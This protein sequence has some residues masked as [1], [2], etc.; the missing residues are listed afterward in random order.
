MAPSMHFDWTET[1]RLQQQRTPQMTLDWMPEDCFDFQDFWAACL[2]ASQRPVTFEIDQLRLVSSANSG[3]PCCCNWSFE[4]ALGWTV[5]LLGVLLGCPKG[6]C[7]GF[8]GQHSLAWMHSSFD[9]SGL[10]MMGGIGVAV[11]RCSTPH[12]FGPSIDRWG[13]AIAQPGVHL[14][15]HLRSAASRSS[16]GASSYHC[17]RWRHHWHHH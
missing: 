10:D 17:H 13:L 14:A 12:W 7:A 6:H 2:L 1:M 3:S 5:G 9:C 8:Q 11:V 4:W 15:M 16:S